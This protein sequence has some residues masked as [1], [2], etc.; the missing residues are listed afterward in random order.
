M[1]P[2]NLEEAKA[3]KPLCYLDGTPA[4]F[5]GYFPES[6]DR[7]QR[8]IVGK[9]HSPTNG[10]MLYCDEEG[11]FAEEGY[12]QM[13]V[14]M[15]PERLT[16]KLDAVRRKSDGQ[17]RLHEDGQDV[18]DQWELIAKNVEVTVPVGSGL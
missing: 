11:F 6:S 17:I 13:N 7:F 16:V 10:S 14:F 2:F 9:M 18:N 1:K 5:I 4:K 8:V 3:G 15:A 12:E